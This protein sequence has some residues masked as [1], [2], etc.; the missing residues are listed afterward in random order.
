MM[1]VFIFNR[2]SGVHITLVAYP[3]LYV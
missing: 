2:R 3:I 1:T